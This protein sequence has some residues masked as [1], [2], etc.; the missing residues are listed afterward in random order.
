[1]RIIQKILF[2]VTGVIGACFGVLTMLLANWGFNLG[3]SAP[4]AFVYGLL[5]GLLL[6]WV[7]AIYV[8]MI[9]MKYVRRKL[10]TKF[11]GVLSIAGSFLRN[12]RF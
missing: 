8:S 6:G 11:G 3:M 5:G 4:E 1:M 7:I 10:M 2:A 12:R 9:I